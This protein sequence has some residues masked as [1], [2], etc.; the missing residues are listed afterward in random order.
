V[1]TD[2]WGVWLFVASKWLARDARSVAASRGMKTS[3]SFRWSLCLA[4]CAVT[5]VASHSRAQDAAAEQ[6]WTVKVYRFPAV[7]LSR[8]F[9]TR[10]RGQLRVPVMPAADAKEEDVVAFM[11]RS[12]DVVGTFLKEQGS[13]TFPE[14]TLFVFDRKSQTLAVRTTEETHR[15][16]ARAANQLKAHVPQYITFS[17][18]ILEAEAAAVRTAVKEAGTKADHTSIHSQLDALTTQGKGKR[19]ATM[20]LETRSGQRATVESALE[21]MYAT[22]FT[23]DEQGRSN[24]VN[25]TRHV[26][27]RL[28]IDPVIGPDGV[29]LDV[30]YSIEHHFAPPTLRWETTALTGPRRLEARTLDF[31]TA[32][33]TSSITLLSGTM[34]LLGIWAPEGAPKAEMPKQLQAAFLRANVVSLLPAQDNRVEQMIT[35]LGEKAMPT[36][37]AP[38]PDAKPKLP[39]LPPG[40]EVRR[41]RV[42]M[43]FLTRDPAMFGAR[44]GAAPADAF[45]PAAAPSEPTVA[46]KMTA[47]DVLRARGI[48]FPDGASASYI[49]ATGELVVR[50]T[51]ENLQ[52]LEDFIDSIRDL[53]PMN[54]AFT[55]HI[56]QGDEAAMRQIEADTAAIADHTEVWRKIEA[57]AAQGR[58]KILRTAWIETR[59]GQRSASKSG[60]EHIYCTSIEALAK[61]VKDT[62][63]G[64]D[65]KT[66]A[67][68]AS[69]VSVSGP[70]NVPTMVPSFDMELIGTEIEVDPV[71]AP[72]GAT[73]DL[74]FAISY[75]TAAPTKRVEPVAPAG[76]VIRVDAA[77]TDFHQARLTTAVTLTNGMTRLL[78]VWKPDM[79]PDGENANVLQAAFVKVDLLKVETEKR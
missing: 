37:A 35:K 17:L 4:W 48:V 77:G 45:A 7:E 41:Y 64:S 52:K 68:H 2:D 40:M 53:A 11:Q 67:P 9:A 36:P 19:L 6:A 32:S 18:H 71:I 12:S 10:D 73:V 21:R 61:K 69:A 15:S 62:T 14:G 25:E 31:Q 8:G 54:V 49:A 22:E 76:D 43:D 79:V 20:R 27:P 63:E 13:I 1:E 3:S 30:N 47:L 56:I 70:G 23:T 78:G 34:K 60:E 28:E 75:D 55:Y 38:A 16:V 42:P 46:M 57:E 39:P 29:T 59:S 24:L 5:L 44:G 72:D 65:A 50:N 74:N 58:I 33:V 26:G 51:P 66:S